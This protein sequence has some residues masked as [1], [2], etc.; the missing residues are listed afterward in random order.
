LTEKQL[1]VYCDGLKNLY[2]YDLSKSCNLCVKSVFLESKF[3]YS[4][5]SSCCRFSRVMSKRPSKIVV[6]KDESKM[7]I[8]DKT[9]DV[10]SLDLQ[11]LTYPNNEPKL[12]MG[13]VSMMTDMVSDRITATINSLLFLLLNL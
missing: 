11:L 12:L 4:G 5:F 2:F 3:I 9:G 8:A 6:L 1:L 7:L 10:Y 13:H